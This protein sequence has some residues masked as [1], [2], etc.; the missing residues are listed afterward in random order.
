[1]TI[2]SSRNYSAVFA[3]SG[4]ECIRIWS[5]GRKQELLRIMVHNFNCAAARFTHDGTSIV[6]VWNDG[7]IRAFTPITGRLI[8]AIPNAHNKGKYLRDHSS[9]KFT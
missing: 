9:N 4:K 5:S 8:Y 6:S 7:I 3:T 1:M 2:P